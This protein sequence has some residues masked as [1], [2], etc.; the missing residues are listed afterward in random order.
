M[1][2][3]FEVGEEGFD[4]EVVVG[5]EGLECLRV[6][7]L[8]LGSTLITHQMISIFLRKVTKVREVPKGWAVHDEP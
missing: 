1:V 8:A 2:V 3:R 6:A 4:V 5:E 7:G